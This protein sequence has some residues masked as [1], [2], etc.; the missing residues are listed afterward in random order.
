MQQLI[1]TF[2]LV[3]FFGFHGLIFKSYNRNERHILAISALNDYALKLLCERNDLTNAA[4][5]PKRFTQDLMH[6]FAKT[7]CLS[8]P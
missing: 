7:E 8:F 5:T 6:L 3:F 4:Q 1:I 2:C